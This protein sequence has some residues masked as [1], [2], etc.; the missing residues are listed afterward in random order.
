MRVENLNQTVRALQRAG[1][2]VSDLKA[3]FS[4]ISAE[5]AR[6]AS[7][8]A[9]KRTGRLAGSVR[10]NKAKNKAVI[11]AGRAR[12]P[13]AGAINYGWRARNIRPSLF[14]QRVDTAIT[15]R[16]ITMLNEGLTE[17]I[18]KAGVDT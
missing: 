13:Y 17:A 7:S 8:F 6:M 1:V 10:G 9:P 18:K 12:I 14:M 5:G 16:A 15:P 11:I 4:A 3:T 2:E